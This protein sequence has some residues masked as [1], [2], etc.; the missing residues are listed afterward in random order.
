MPVSTLTL[1]SIICLLVGG[2]LGAV[3]TTL[4]VD[5]RNT[6]RLQEVMQTLATVS[7]E[8]AAGITNENVEA[9]AAMPSWLKTMKPKGAHAG[10]SLV[11]IQ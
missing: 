4:R 9:S 1:V 7:P 2:I 3:S 5:R 10:I 11:V 6:E 8:A